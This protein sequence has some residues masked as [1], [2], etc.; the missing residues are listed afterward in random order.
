MKVFLAEAIWSVARLGIVQAFVGL[1]NRRIRKDAAA[2]HSARFLSHSSVTRVTDRLLEPVHSLHETESS[3]S[4]RDRIGKEGH[5]CARFPSEHSLRAALFRASVALCRAALRSGV[6]YFAHVRGSLLL[7]GI[8][9][10]T[11]LQAD[12]AREWEADGSRAC[13]VSSATFTAVRS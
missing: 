5:L 2:K 7:R 8:G 12:G 6:L 9:W 13:H 11:Q 1:L 4:T 3:G 10:S